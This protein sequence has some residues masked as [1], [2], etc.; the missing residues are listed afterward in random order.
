[1]YAPNFR[2]R[3]R[4]F[5]LVELMVSMVIG[6]LVGLTALASVQFFTGMQRQS[7]GIGASLANAT[8]ALSAI[9]NEANQ[10]GLGLYNKGSLTCGTFNM[11]TGTTTALNNTAMAPVSLTT[12]E[13]LPVLQLSYATALDSAGAA[14]LATDLVSTATSAQLSTY[15][16]VSAGQAVLLAPPAEL[17]DTVPCS[18]KTVTSVTTAAGAGPTLE[19]A[20]TGSH[21][22]VNFTAVTYPQGSPFVLL[23]AL[24]NTTFSVDASGNLV[25]ARPLE[26]TS[27]ILAKNVVAMGMQYGI[28]EIGSPTI[29]GWRY[30]LGYPLRASGAEDWSTLTPARL[31]QV[32]AI[33]VAVLVRSTQKDSKVAGACATTQ[34]MP[35][36]LGVALGASPAAA[37]GLF[38]GAT[39]APALAGDWQCYRYQETSVTVPLRNLIWGVNT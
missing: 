38:T 18:I 39:I 20:A 35:S 33:K 28:S 29:S 8:T 4:G 36:L 32:K 14:T 11:S 17:R 25:M 13:G 31:S 22:K 34:A 7:L 6:L 12:V 3:Q 26:G 19:F 15:L 24:R 37:E 5:T 30:P 21:N 2:S 16:P 27:A 9:K 23:G 10:A 1:M